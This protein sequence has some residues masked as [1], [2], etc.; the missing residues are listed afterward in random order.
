MTAKHDPDIENAVVEYAKVA[1]KWFLA[2][3]HDQDAF[4]ARLRAGIAVK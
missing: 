1:Q 3:L 2:R 4:E